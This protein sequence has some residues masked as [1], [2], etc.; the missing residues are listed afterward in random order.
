MVVIIKPSDTTQAITTFIT[1]GITFQLRKLAPSIG[2]VIWFSLRGG[3]P[4]SDTG[5]A[6]RKTSFCAV[7][8]RSMPDST[9]PVLLKSKGSTSQL[10][11]ATGRKA[12][13]LPETGVIT[14]LTPMV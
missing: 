4:P 10:I 6:I 9:K 14:G 12:S 1:S 5:T 7:M 13:I 2:P 8:P 11:I 3:S